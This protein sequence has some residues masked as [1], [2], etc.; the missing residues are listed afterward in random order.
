MPVDPSSVGCLFAIGSFCLLARPASPPAP[1][2]GCQC[3]CGATGLS[4]SVLLAVA[5]GQLAVG[6][7]AGRFVF[8]APKAA[9][10]VL[11]TEPARSLTLPAGARRVL[12][13]SL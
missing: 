6:Y 9:P 8:G 4:T 13:G 11:H 10:V 12:E 7:F 3:D 2:C 5:L 1:V